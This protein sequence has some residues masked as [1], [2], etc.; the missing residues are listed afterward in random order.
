MFRRYVFCSAIGAWIALAVGLA[1]PS[2]AADAIITDGDTLI[3]KGTLYRLQGIEA[4][5]T[6]QVCLNENGAAWT[7][8]V[9]A[10]DRLKDFVSK[11]DVRCDDLGRDALYSKRRMG[12]CWIEGEA[13]SINQW[14]VREGWAL[15]LGRPGKSRFEADRERAAADKK[16]L[17]KGCFV[18][19]EALRRCT[20]STAQLLGAACPKS[21]N[22]T[23][24]EML[25]PDHP[26]RPPGC[27][28]KGRVAMRSQIGGHRGI[29]H[30]EGC[31]SYQRTPKPHRWF[32]SE[33]EAQAE[34]FRKSYTC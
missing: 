15:A 7:C 11:R 16:G 17:W 22:W 3:L 32:C 5:Q 30:L 13:V 27:A 4:P 28:I 26:A 18:S 31:R 25:F 34:G 2:M 23:V 19:P 8:G 24:R 21:N 6:D 29:Y 1:S 14:M 10:R 12:V 33:D 20:I 9:E